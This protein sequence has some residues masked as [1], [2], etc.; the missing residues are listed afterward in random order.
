MCSVLSD[1]LV[2]HGI[3]MTTKACAMQYQSRGLSSQSPHRL[4]KCKGWMA[5]N[6]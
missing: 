5:G 6:G 4:H 2:V 3:V 1:V